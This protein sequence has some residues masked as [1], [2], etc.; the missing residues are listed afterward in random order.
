MHDSS[1]SVSKVITAALWAWVVMVL[2]AAW[3]AWLFGHHELAAMLGLTACASSAAAATA[4][5]RCYMVR[6]CG[7][8][9]AVSDH[10]GAPTIQL[11]PMR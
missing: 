5:I 4:H 1:I 2:L 7:L 8:L 9:R 10:E 3:T 11:R 6:T